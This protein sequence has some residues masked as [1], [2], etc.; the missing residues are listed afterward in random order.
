MPGHPRRRNFEGA[1]ITADW[2]GFKHW[3]GPLRSEHLFSSDD[4][5][6]TGDLQG[7]IFFL[8][9]CSS[10]GAW[11]VESFMF[12]ST[13]KPQPQGEDFVASLPKKLLGSA[14]G[15]ALAVIGHIGTTWQMSLEW[16]DAGLQPQTISTL[17]RSLMAGQ[18]VGMAMHSLTRRYA[19]L[20]CVMIDLVADDLSVSSADRSHMWA[21]TM[22]ARDYIILGDPAVNIGN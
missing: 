21:A 22:D 10:A 14:P 7:A 20:A 6:T 4:V 13:E 18:P 2:P 12:P 1:I 8:L 17:L 5:A 9:A 15:G 16:A 19:E 11:A 3:R